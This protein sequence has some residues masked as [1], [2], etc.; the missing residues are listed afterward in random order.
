M[1]DLDATRLPLLLSLESDEAIDWPDAD[2]LWVLVH[3]IGGEADHF[4]ILER[5]PHQPRSFMQTYRDA[6][7]FELE[8]RDGDQQFQTRVSD[9]DTVLGTMVAWARNEPDW[10]SRHPWELAFQHAP[11]DISAL[12]PTAETMA[13]AQIQELLAIG[14]ESFPD[15]ARIVAEATEDD[16]PISEEQARV[17]LEPLWLARV[18]EQESWPQITDVDRVEAALDRLAA[19]G[20]T[21]E[22]YFACCLRCGVGEIRDAAAPTDRGYVFFHEQDAEHAVDGTLHLASGAYSR[23][24]AESLAI[25]HEVVAALTEQ[26]LTTRWDGTVGQ[27]VAVVDLDW[28]KRLE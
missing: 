28:K 18:A 17:L 26:G 5:I 23:D 8:Y 9:P 2:E 10:Q 12:D 24:E 20:L 19:K 14:Y 7:G 27:R 25:A 16:A 11:V 6:E 15:I 4:L 22:A 21:T 13:R 1:N 3:R